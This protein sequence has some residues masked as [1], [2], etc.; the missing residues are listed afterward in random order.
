VLAEDKLDIDGDGLRDCEERFYGTSRLS[1]DSDRDGLP[2]QVEIRF[3]TNP[4][5][6]DSEKDADFDRTSNGQEVRTFGDPRNNDAVTRAA[7]AYRYQVLNDGLDGPRSCRDFRIENITLVQT[8]PED[9]NDSAVLDSGEDANVNGILDAGEDLDGNGRL[10]FTEDANGNGELDPE[11]WNLLWVYAGQVPFDDP[12]SA[13]D[14]RVACVRAR[15]S[16]T[17]NLKDPPGGFIEIQEED[18][19]PP[20][21]LDTT[22]DC[23]GP[24]Q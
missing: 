4:V 21:E 16:R 3:G 24:Y 15:F 12:G 1:F 14:Y 11:G 22:V 18:F 7:R 17:A 6:D 2:D 10:S 9:L 23:V 19:H 8:L 13:V 20:T 5:D